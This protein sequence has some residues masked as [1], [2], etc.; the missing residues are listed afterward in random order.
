MAGGYKSCPERRDVIIEW[1]LSCGA[2]VFALIPLSHC[3]YTAGPTLAH[4][5]ALAASLASIVIIFAAGNQQPHAKTAFVWRR[6]AK[7]NQRQS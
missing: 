1:P 6:A 7:H 3:Q 2:H 4:A 5:R